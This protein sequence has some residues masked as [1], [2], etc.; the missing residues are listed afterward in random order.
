MQVHTAVAEASQL[1]DAAFLSVHTTRDEILPSAELAF[2]GA[3]EAFRQGKIGSLDLRDAERT[4]FDARR[5][6]T[7]A[8]TSYHLAVIVGERLIGAPLHDD[9]RPQG[10]E[11]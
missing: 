4:L 9:G 11:Q 3:E 1:L 10:N 6:L 5:Q 8:L 2:K 7:A